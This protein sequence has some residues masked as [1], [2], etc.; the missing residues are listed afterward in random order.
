LTDGLSVIDGPACEITPYRITI[1][2]PGLP[3]VFAGSL[4]GV[5]QLDG[6]ID[7]YP[8]GTTP[9]ATNAFFK[10]VSP[11]GAPGRIQFLYSTSKT[12]PTMIPLAA[13]G[14]A[15]WIALSAPN[16]YTASFIVGESCEGTM[17]PVFSTK[18]SICLARYEQTSYLFKAT[19]S[20][21]VGGGL[22]A[23]GVLADSDVFTDT[24][25]AVALARISGNPTL[26][27]LTA[28]PARSSAFVR[29]HGGSTGFAKYDLS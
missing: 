12:Q 24:G 8:S 10:Q 1:S 27:P 28:A 17:N 9:P 20:A 29:V 14:D 15:L 21:I 26:P 19:M 6:G 18:H 13:S 16:T 11:T 22:V 4:S 7:V 23:N 2:P 25:D 5:C 3:H